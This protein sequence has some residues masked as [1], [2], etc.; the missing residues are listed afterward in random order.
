MIMVFVVWGQ[1]HSLEEQTVSIFRFKVCFLLGLF[2]DPDY[3]GD[4]FLQNTV[5]YLIYRVLQPR[6]QLCE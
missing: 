5:L 2:F 1:P 4:M 6:I 3:G